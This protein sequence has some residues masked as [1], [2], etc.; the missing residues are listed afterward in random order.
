[1]RTIRRAPDC[2]RNISIQ[3]VAC[4]RSPPARR[5][6]TEA[7]RSDARN[8]EAGRLAERKQR[9]Y[10]DDF[11]ELK[12]YRAAN[13]QLKPPAAGEKRVVFFGDSITEL[14]PFAAVPGQAL[15]QPRH[16]RPDDVAA[17]GAL[18]RRRD[19]ARP[20]GGR[21]PGRH[22]RHRRQHRPDSLEEIEGNF[23]T[24]VE[25]AR[26]HGIRV[27]LSSV[28]PVHNY[29][30]VSELTFPRR[31]PAQIAAL[32]KWLK[33]Y[34]ATSGCVYLDYAAAMADDKGLFEADL[35]EDGL[36]PN[37]AGYA[38]MAP[39][40]EQAIGKALQGGVPVLG[41]G[42]WSLSCPPSEHIAP[43]V[44]FV[45]LVWPL[46]SP[47]VAAAAPA[48]RRQRPTTTSPAARGRPGAHAADG[49]EQLERVRSA[50]STRTSSS[51]PPT[52]G[53]D[54][55][56]GRRLPYYIRMHAVDSESRGPRRERRAAAR[57][58]S[59]RSA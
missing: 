21:H 42:V 14:W 51:A 25:L 24:M 46:C 30:P 54:G 3:L 35:A 56:E 57:E 12:R 4:W 16:R 26:A 53:V 39:L 48:A 52:D 6:A 32:N 17:A 11:G 8:G 55:H 1:M 20:Q 23:A 7:R 22:K 43:C 49:V 58:R 13:A 47:R 44:S 41:A 50:T 37:K 34:A 27:V 15:R 40:A 33:D 29:T 36:H 59:Q 31:P 9:V 10:M 18:P 38:I 5:P 2:I 28:I 19:R 45:Y